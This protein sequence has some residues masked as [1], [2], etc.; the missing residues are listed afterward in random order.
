MTSMM[1]I[2]AV[3]RSIGVLQAINRRPQSTVMEIARDTDLP[4]PT[5]FRL[6][7]T[8]L[9]EGLIESEP[10]RKRY[11]P[12]ELV[13]TL[14]IGFQD[15][16]QLA[17]LARPHLTDLTTRVGWPVAVLARVGSRMMVKDSTHALTTQTFTNYYPG[18]TLPL[19][20]CASGR[21]YLAFCSDT[22]RDIA[23]GCGED[24][25]DE[26]GFG[27][28][29]LRE[30]GI[31]AK[32]RT[33]GYATNARNALSPTPGKTSSIAIPIMADGALLACLT[34]IFFSNAQPMDKAIA[35]YLGLLQETAQAIGDSV[36]EVNSAEL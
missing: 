31:L 1:P 28:L 14:S 18:Y 20:D 21:C 10:N 2:R 9:Y 25:D 4:Y 7:Q 6:I 32:I 16:D 3:S 36:R 24:M 17:A 26:Q 27:K 30:P 35:S 5:V 13:R 33:L 12:T 11:R 22:E 34:L 8:L 19:L 15:K 23:I 29:L